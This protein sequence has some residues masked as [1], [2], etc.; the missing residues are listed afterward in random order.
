MA[1]K[2]EELQ[3]RATELGIE[4]DDSNTIAELEEAIAEVEG[5][6]EEEE[7][8][9]EDAPEEKPEPVKGDFEVYGSNGKLFRTVGTQEEAEHLTSVLGGRYVKK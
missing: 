6:E 1:T 4:F 3:A 5:E 8:P 2:K 7:T 9:A